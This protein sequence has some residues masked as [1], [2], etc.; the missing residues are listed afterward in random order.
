MGCQSLHC[1][2]AAN[3]LCSMVA[4]TNQVL[5]C[6]TGVSYTI[7]TSTWAKT[8]CA[9]VAGLPNPPYV[10]AAYCKVII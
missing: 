3:T 7:G 9:P 2:P 4:N 1:T 5:G 8:I 10:S 6:Y